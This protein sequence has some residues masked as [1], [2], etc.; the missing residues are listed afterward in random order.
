MSSIIT[1]KICLCKTKSKTEIQFLFCI[2]GLFG[3]QKQFDS[4]HLHHT[5]KPLS[6][7]GFGVFLCPVNA[8]T[9]LPPCFIPHS[10]VDFHAALTSYAKRFAKQNPPPKSPWRAFFNIP[11]SLKA[12]RPPPAQAPARQD[13]P[14]PYPR[15]EYSCTPDTQGSN[16]SAP[17]SN[18]ENSDKR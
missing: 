12:P 2:N 16:A 1:I 11:R 5:P 8:F 4:P 15:P 3:F 13:R 9:L 14:A 7:N 17:P 10:R 6:H 18:S